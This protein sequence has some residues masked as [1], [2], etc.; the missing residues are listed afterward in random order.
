MRTY[1][2]ALA[3][4]SQCGRS[5]RRLRDGRLGTKMPPP[6]VLMQWPSGDVHPPPRELLL[7]VTLARYHTRTSAQMRRTRTTPMATSK[8]R[9]PNPRHAPNCS[10]PAHGPTKF[11]RIHHTRAGAQLADRLGSL[12]WARRSGPTMHHR[13][14]PLPHQYPQTATRH[15]GRRCRT[16][17]SCR[18]LSMHHIPYATR[19]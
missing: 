12:C 3:K 13:T 11:D 15:H 16:M 17:Y 8:S 10:R 7:A 18:Y 9:M 5:A 14:P 2:R 6:K 1:R 19:T 4:K